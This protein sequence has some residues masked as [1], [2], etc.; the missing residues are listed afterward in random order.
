[1]I[2]SVCIDDA[3]DICSIFNHYVSH[4]IVTFEEAPVDVGE[5]K[6]RIQKVTKTHPW[7]V[8]EDEG[9]IIGY[10]YAGRWA[11]RSA[12]RF[13]TESTVYVDPEF[14]RRKIGYRVLDRVVRELKNKGF[15]TTMGGIALPN[16]A[17]IGL[18]EKLGFVKVAH[19]KDV[20]MKFGTWIDV[21]YW[22]R[23][24]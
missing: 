13:A 2:R 8:Y 14:T 23:V 22:Q 7:F 10:A 9:R 1:M 19:F 20:G 5:V 16:D 21:G 24:L 17:S 15:H 3:E 18:H 6:R 11:E 12:Y 4:T